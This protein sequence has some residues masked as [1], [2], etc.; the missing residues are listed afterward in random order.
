MAKEK[1]RYSSAAKDA[2]KASSDKGQ[3]DNRFKGSYQFVEGYLNDTDKQWLND[4]LDGSDEMVYS[5]VCELDPCFKLSVSFDVRSDRYLAS[6]ARIDVGHSDSGKILVSR[7]ATR[8]DA[9]YA[10]A[11]RFKVKFSAGWG[12]AS[13]NSASR[14]E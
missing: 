10:L 14:W 11:Y 9:L 6:I 4:N 2:G 13:L 12:E 3:S 8:F 1:G 7:G 5:L